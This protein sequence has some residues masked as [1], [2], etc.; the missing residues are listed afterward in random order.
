MTSRNGFE[1]ELVRLRVRQ[2]NSRPNPP[3]TCGKVER[4]QQTMKRWLTVRPRAATIDQL[5]QLLDAFVDDYDHRRPHRSLQHHSA[6]A[7]AYTARPKASPDTD[8]G[9][10]LRVRHDRVDK[11]GKVTLRHLTLDPTRIYQPT[12]AKRG[13]P[14]RPYGPYGPRKTK[15]SEP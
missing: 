7:V 11:A 8:T 6:P 15:Q 9:S 4:F 1:T 5:Q 3:T 12:G 2:K 10:D 13:G 14:S